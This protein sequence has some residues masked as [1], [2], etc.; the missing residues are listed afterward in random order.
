M[1]TELFTFMKPKT[2]HLF[3]TGVPRFARSGMRREDRHIF[4]SDRSTSAANISVF[5]TDWFEGALQIWLWYENL[6][7]WFVSSPSSHTPLSCHVKCHLEAE[8]SLVHL[9]TWIKKVHR[10]ETGRPH[11]IHPLGNCTIYNF[12]YF[13]I[14]M[15]F[16]TRHKS[17]MTVEIENH[18][19]PH[20]LFYFDHK[21][22]PFPKGQNHPNGTTTFHRKERWNYHIWLFSATKETCC[23][24]VKGS[25]TID[26][27]F[28]RE[29]V[30]RDGSRTKIHLDESKVWL[31]VTY[32]P[33]SN[34][35]QILKQPSC[36]TQL[37]HI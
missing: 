27:K 13:C 5:Y 19:S 33:H 23:I 35:Q 20:N 37:T 2:L 11:N 30:S 36:R 22:N 17:F 18:L 16:N 32:L 4:V 34:H 8:C 21:K 10:Y 6:M 31:C 12:L 24:F 14:N 3:V 7:K 1:S 15:T 29:G 28:I 25:P 26:A 9:C